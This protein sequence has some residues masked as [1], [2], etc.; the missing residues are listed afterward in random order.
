[1]CVSRQRE[2]V[3]PGY[4][5]RRGCFCTILLNQLEGETRTARVL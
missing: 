5:I 2:K 4:L 1:V 3:K